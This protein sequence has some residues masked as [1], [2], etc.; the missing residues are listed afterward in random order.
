MTGVNV[1][2]LTGLAIVTIRGLSVGKWVHSS[3][4]ALMVTT[5]A[6]LL[7]LPWLNLAHRT[8][9]EFHPLATAVPALSILSLNIA[10]KMGFGALGGFEYVA[11][12]AGECRDD[13]SI[14]RSVW[15]AAP[16]ICVMH[17]GHELGARARAVRS[18]DLIAPIPQ[19][20]RWDSAA[21]V[22]RLGGAPHDHHPACIRLAQAGV[23]FTGITRLPMVAGWDGLLPS[24]SSCIRA[25]GRR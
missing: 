13:R 4:G 7:M 25:S 9:H 19:H 22:H 20:S 1:A 16:I 15:T 10:A 18:D 2:I 8:L 14:A 12:H 5:F 3:G 6:M 23:M 24:G 21:S 17:P 11:I